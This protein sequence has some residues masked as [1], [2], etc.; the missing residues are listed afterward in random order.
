MDLTGFAINALITIATLF[1]FRYMD[2]KFGYRSTW[3]QRETE[4]QNEIR[5][6]RDRVIYLENEYRKSVE[7]ELYAHREIEDL[8]GQIEK[9]Q[10]QLPGAE[11]FRLERKSL[12]V[13]LAKDVAGWMDLAAARSS[14]VALSISR[15]NA[16][17]KAKLKRYIDRGRMYNR[18]VELLHIGAHAS[19]DGV[20]F[21]DGLADAS[22]M[23]EHLAG[24]KV[25]LIASCSAD[26]LGDWLGVVPYVVTLTEDV[27][28]EDAAM[29]SRSFWS[30]IG[31]GRDPETALANSLQRAPSGMS[32]YVERH[33]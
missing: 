7:R 8:R 15:I 12:L 1:S 18:P 3:M 11:Q 26:L 13:A 28:D 25:L 16:V 4:L 20:L 17:T 30:E 29:F 32:E 5:T 19:K 6:L 10:A 31:A 24:V 27:T 14:P 2:A 9:M 23:S 22:W 33:W 21:G